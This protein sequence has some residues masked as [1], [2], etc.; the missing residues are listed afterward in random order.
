MTTAALGTERLL[1]FFVPAEDAV[2]PA[3]V[4]ALHAPGGVA[5]AEL[6]TLVGRVR[7]RVADG[8]GL[9]PWRVIPVLDAAYDDNRLTPSLR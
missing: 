6:R 9:S 8:L 3:A 7:A 2:S 4:A 5:A 1:V